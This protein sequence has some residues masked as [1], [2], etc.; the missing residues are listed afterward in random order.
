MAN[1]CI[2]PEIE[3]PYDN[4]K[5][6]SLEEKFNSTIVTANEFIEIPPIC[7]EIMEGEYN[8]EIGTL[9]NI[10]LWIGKAKQGK[11]FAMSL[12]LA[13]AETGEWLMDKIKI[14]LPDTN[15]N[16]I[17][18]DT[19][20][21]KFHL[22]R[23]IKR[24]AKL[25]NRP[26]PFNL[27]SSGLR[28]YPPH[29]RLELIEHALYSI[30]GIGFV[31]IDGIK[32]L[33]TS[34]NDEEQASMISS[35]LLKWSEELNIHIAVVLHT[36]KGDNNARG[37]LGTELTNKAESVISVGKDE[38]NKDQ[39]IIKPEYCRSKEFNPFAFKIDAYGVPYISDIPI[40]DPAGNGASRKALTPVD[41]P[42]ETHL[43]VL[44][45]VFRKNKELKYSDLIPQIKDYFMRHNI[46]FGENKAKEFAT[47]YQNDNF[48]ES[49]KPEKGHQMYRM[50][51]RLTPYKPM[52]LS[53][54]IQFEITDNFEDDQ[55]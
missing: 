50:V 55:F 23:V 36:N 9:G 13:A 4:I 47:F 46:K 24:I 39:M 5:L 1:I 14:T 18:F 19:E 21:S 40:I 26:E 42:T 15:K 8:S 52:K 3:L 31:V 6:S 16:V 32:D 10:S 51:S 27:T 25:S 49:F 41:I 35:K 29:E 11:T 54:N 12:A 48:I 28:K 30:E 34:I 44:D 17:L 22:Q 2:D 7:F 53:P 45:A 20:Q 33:I 37:H 43:L 38:N